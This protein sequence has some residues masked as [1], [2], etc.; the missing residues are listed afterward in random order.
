MRKKKGRGR[1]FTHGDMVAA[2]ED[3]ELYTS[4]LIVQAWADRGNEIEELRRATIRR[5]LNRMAERHLGEPEGIVKIQG[6]PRIGGWKGRTWKTL[7]E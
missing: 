2:L 6:Q 4:S 5:N 3:H 7:L 1:P